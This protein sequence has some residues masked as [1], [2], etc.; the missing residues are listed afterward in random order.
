MLELFEVAIDK[1]PLELV[2]Q[3]PAEEVYDL[4]Y[5]VAWLQPL[6]PCAVFLSQLLCALHPSFECR[7]DVL[8]GVVFFYLSTDSDILIYKYSIV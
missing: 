1:L 7:V 2:F 4:S 5:V 3:G 8:T 6:S